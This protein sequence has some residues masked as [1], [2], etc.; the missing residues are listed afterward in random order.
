MTPVL[1]LVLLYILMNKAEDL[2][3]LTDVDF[4]KRPM[5]PIVFNL[6]LALIKNNAFYPIS[7]DTCMKWFAYDFD[8]SLMTPKSLSVVDK[9]TND[10]LAEYCSE[11][12]KSTPFFKRAGDKGIVADLA[13]GI[14]EL[15]K[16]PYNYGTP[17]AGMEKI[18][19]GAIY[20]KNID[21]DLFDIRLMINDMR[22]MEYHLNN[23]LTK[24]SFKLNEL[25]IKKMD[26]ELGGIRNRLKNQNASFPVAC[27]DLVLDHIGRSHGFDGHRHAERRSPRQPQSSRGVGLH[28]HHAVGPRQD[29]LR[30]SVDPGM[31]LA[32]SSGHGSSPASLHVQRRTRT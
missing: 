13:A 14:A 23:G 11:V 30:L 16:Q 4:H 6:P 15:N 28:L 9:I 1:I 20:F 22:L 7:T 8:S 2:I 17:T 12:S 29:C 26:D 5:I 27:C 10:P 32:M 21:A 24:Q 31:R 18:P 3:S 19:D 25:L